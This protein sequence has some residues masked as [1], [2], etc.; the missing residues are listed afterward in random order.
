M[1]FFLK[2]DHRDEKECEVKRCCIT[3]VCQNMAD[4]SVAYRLVVH[5]TSNTNLFLLYLISVS[6]FQG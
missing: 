5:A 4:L 2:H 6:L 1:T 3:S